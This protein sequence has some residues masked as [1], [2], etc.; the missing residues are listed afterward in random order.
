MTTLSR[1]SLVGGLAVGGG[2]VATAALGEP[3]RLEIDQL[4]K[5]ADTACVYHCDFGDP[6]RLQQMA[7][8]ISNHLSVYDADPFKLKIVVVAHGSGIK[9]FLKDLE[10]T[11]WSDSP[12]PPEI[13]QRFQ[14]LSKSGVE[15]YLCQITFKHNKIDLAKARS[16]DFI[17]LV[18][19]GVAT[20]AALQGKGYAYIKA[21]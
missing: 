5:D 17:R 4:K 3:K 6:K 9:P 1:R 20:V 14:D 15:V 21:G 10:G 16:D 18:P 8:N 12:M 7:G 2:L 11:P 19:S 13:F